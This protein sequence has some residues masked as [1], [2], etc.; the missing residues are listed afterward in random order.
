MTSLT[1][2]SIS[3]LWQR[4]FLMV[5]AQMLHWCGPTIKHCLYFNAKLD[6][7]ILRKAMEGF[8]CDKDTIVQVLCAR[9]NAQRQQ[10]AREFKVLYKKDIKK[11]LKSELSG[12]FEELIL[13]LMETPVHFICH[14]LR[15][16]MKGVGT[17]E[18]VL[19]EVLISHSNE[20]IKEIKHEYYRLFDKKLDK[21]II[22]ET[23][24][25]FQRLLVCLLSAGRD[26]TRH[27]DNYKAESD[28]RLLYEAWKKK[29]AITE[30]VDFIKMLTTQN[31]DQIRLL[32]FKY[33]QIA[34]HPIESAIETQFR[35]GDTRDALLAL[36][37]RIRNRTAYF[38][39]QLDKYTEGILGTRDT[40]LIRVIVSRSEIDLVDIK[41]EFN[42]L[43]GV[44]LERAL[45]DSCSGAYKDALIALVKGN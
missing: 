29:C 45:G 35:G 9:S 12:A 32:F 26:E 13:A 37:R 23:S 40:D 6:A 1:D 20:E 3:A 16:A 42:R 22:G 43:Q 38:A 39:G 33:N 18:N 14:Q 44:P 5:Q 34:G 2:L 25:E 36:A 10:I 8:G 28:A 15:K 21:D 27:T 24:G 4:A 19:V 11:E 17:R 7:E 41:M 31:F 30:E